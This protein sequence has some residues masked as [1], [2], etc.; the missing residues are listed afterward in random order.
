MQIK[1]TAD[2]IADHI[3]DAIFSGRYLPGDRLKEAEIASWLAVSR[4]PVRESLHKLE[5][6]GLAESQ[7][8]KGVIV[9]LIDDHDI[10]E[11][12]ELRMLIEL[13]CIRKFIRIASERHFEEMEEILGQMKNALSNKNIPS[14]FA[15]SLD[16]HDYYIKNCQNERMYAFFCSIRNSMR[17]AQSILRETDAFC[18]KSLQEHQEIMRLL[19]NRS[20]DCET[21]LRLHIEDACSRMRGKTKGELY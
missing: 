9:P 10:D 15:L 12:C 19:K 7:P 5:A 4:T 17:I 8:N 2:Q 16:F 1:S 20:K 3:R 14:Y 6:E 11:I 21:A 18:R 13:Y